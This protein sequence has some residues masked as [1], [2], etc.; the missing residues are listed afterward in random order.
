M[1]KV[2]FS[3]VCAMMVVL[4]YPRVFSFVYRLVPVKWWNE[5]IAYGQIRDVCNPRIEDYQALQKFLAKARRPSLARLGDMEK[6][7]RHFCLIGKDPVELPQEGK[8]TVNCGKDEKENCLIIYAS[9]NKAYPQGLRRLV[10]HVSKSDFKGHILYRIGGWPNVAEGDLKLAHV[11]YAFKPC[12]FREAQ[13][14]G[15]R[16]VLW[17][18]ASIQPVVSLNRIFEEI[19]AKGYFAIGNGQYVA[20]FINEQAAAGLGI[21]LKECEKIPSVSAGLFGVDFSHEKAALAIAKWHQ[22][23]RDTAAFFSARPDQNALSVILFQLDMQNWAPLSKIA[24]SSEL[25]SKNIYFKIDRGYVQ[26]GK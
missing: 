15:Y 21:T 16:R 19:A 11:P 8:I 3:L 17:L 10:D 18:D 4:L 9:F 25:L 12:F 2:I 6:R 23:A 14:L 20:P 1:R 22:A 13:Q 26:Y 5:R 7:A 24:E